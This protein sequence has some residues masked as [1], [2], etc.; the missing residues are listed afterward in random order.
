MFSSSRCVFEFWQ[1]T[2]H[3]DEGRRADVLKLPGLFTVVRAGETGIVG[4]AVFDDQA[5]IPVL[6]SRHPGQEA[7]NARR[8]GGHDADG[9]EYDADF[10]YIR[11]HP[12]EPVSG[13]LAGAGPHVGE[14]DG[15]AVGAKASL[16]LRPPWDY[17]PAHEIANRAENHSPERRMA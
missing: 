8:I 14:D 2:I 10:G 7:F 1:P 15:G 17:S 9:G 16:A 3:S 4:D 11:I 5:G 13:D 6:E 12:R